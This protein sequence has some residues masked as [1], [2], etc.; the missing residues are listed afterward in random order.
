M[1]GSIIV[2]QVFGA[3]FAAS[4]GGMAIAF[5]INM[6]ASSIISKAFGA[7]PPNFNDN[8]GPSAENPGS[9]TQIPPAGDNKVPV[10]YGSAYVGGI[11]TDLSITS[12]NQN[13]Y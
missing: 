13:L 8:Q 6:V 7:E 2:A 1:P 3:A 12:D 5:A 10:V 4:V 9:R 11:V